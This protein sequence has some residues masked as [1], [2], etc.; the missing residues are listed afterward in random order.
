MGGGGEE[1]SRGSETDLFTFFLSLY[2]LAYSSS[3]MVAA[4]RASYPPTLAHERMNACDVDGEFCTGR[5]G[6][7]GR[8]E[9]G[10]GEGWGGS[11]F[12]CIL[13]KRLLVDDLIRE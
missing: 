4:L 1:R 13:R 12:C 7:Y 8:G 11:V 5:I 3:Y 10:L 6:V 9:K 2:D